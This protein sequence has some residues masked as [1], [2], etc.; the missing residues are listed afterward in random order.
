MA[1]QQDIKNCNVM[2]FIETLLDPLV[3]DCAI[4]PHG[5]SIHRQDRTQTLGKIKGGG[6]DLERLMIGCRPY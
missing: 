1:F 6:G 3:P 4:V 5:L 2:V